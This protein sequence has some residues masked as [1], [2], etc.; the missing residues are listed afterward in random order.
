MTIRVLVVDD[1]GF[2]RRRLTEI[3]NA[4]SA[5]SVI[6]TAVNGAEGVEK[7]V[8]LTPDVV[9]MDVEMPVMDGINAVRRI[10]M[11]RPTPI[12]MFSSLTHEGAQ[13]TLDAIEAGATDFLPKR[14]QDIAGDYGEAKRRLCARVRAIAKKDRT[15][16]DLR[17][18]GALRVPHH[19]GMERSSSKKPPAGRHSPIAHKLVVIGT[20]TG[21]PVALQ[22][23]L[24][25]LPADFSLPLLLIQHMPA[26]FTPAFAQRLDQHCAVGVREA[27]DGDVVQSGTA[28]LAPGGRQM[29]VE[30]LNGK[31]VVRVRDSRPNEHYQP[32][33]DVSFT[34]SADV[35]P[36]QVLAIVLTGM[37]A[38]GRE[39]ARLLKQGSSTVWAQNERS[40]VVYGMPMAVIE[41]G[42]A[43]RILPLSEIGSSLAGAV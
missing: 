24:G 42:I 9:T 40:C 7:V 5:I 27:R 3:L 1:S 37:G 32:S 14:L 18:D 30:K 11:T 34:S 20:S 15:P 16:P 39:G 17:P 26:T 31:A 4:D 23:V 12:L 6:D 13:A 38:D 29:V 22:A 10:M 2:F 19:Q 35:F 36:G 25:G 8:R 43:D 33:V 41:A 21:G 28:L